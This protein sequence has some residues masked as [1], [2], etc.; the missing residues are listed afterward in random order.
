MTER[1]YLSILKDQPEVLTVP[2]VAKILRIGK[3]KAYAL[4]SSGNIKAIKI[5]AKTIVP[6][7]H[8][9]GFLMDTKS[10]QF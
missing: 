10:Y 4:V 9:I 1:E 7:M 2:E 3:N 5:G 6:K 8:L